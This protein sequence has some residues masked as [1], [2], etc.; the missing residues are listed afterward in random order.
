MMMLMGM[1]SASAPSSVK[2]SSIMSSPNEKSPSPCVES[3][4]KAESPS[5]LLISM[6][7]SV[8]QKIMGSS[9]VK[10]RMVGSFEVVY[11]CVPSSLKK[12]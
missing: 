5:W 9:V 10:R 6:S 3:R 1:L 8:K 11:S 2:I 4:L 7:R 12:K